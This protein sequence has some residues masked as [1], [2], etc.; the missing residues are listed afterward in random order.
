MQN[1]PHRGGECLGEKSSGF[2]V[3][4]YTCLMWLSLYVL[5]LNFVNFAGFSQLSPVKSDKL[6]ILSFS[7]NIVVKSLALI[8]DPIKTLLSYFGTKEKSYLF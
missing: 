8:G 4:G 1:T 2:V 7:V 3:F 6:D 5:C